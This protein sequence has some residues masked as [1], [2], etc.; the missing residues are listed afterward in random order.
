MVITPPWT[1][2]GVDVPVIASIF[3]SSV[4]TLSVTLIWLP[5]APDATKVIVVPLTVMVSFVAKLDVSEFV[6]EVPDSAV[7]PV[8]RLRA[9]PG[10]CSR[11]RSPN[12][13]C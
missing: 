2:D 11:R 13:R 10:C 3:D 7:A 12:C 9:S 4:C 6:P 5:V 1:V 8:M